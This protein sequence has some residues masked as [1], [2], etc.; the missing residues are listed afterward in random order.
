M[1]VSG[2]HGPSCLDTG[3]RMRMPPEGTLAVRAKPGTGEPARRVVLRAGADTV[4]G[5]RRGSGGPL[6]IP[7]S[8]GARTCERGSDAATKGAAAAT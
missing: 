6:A 2:H 7:P 3:G 4:A 5:F 8:S 1:I